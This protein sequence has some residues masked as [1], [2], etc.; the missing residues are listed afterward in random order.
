MSAE[1]LITVV[2]GVA[3]AAMGNVLY[4]AIQYLFPQRQRKE[5]GIEN[6]VEQLTRALK[7]ATGLIGNIEA[8]ITARSNLAAQYKRT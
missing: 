1:L 6:R 7:D 2:T 4:S 3:V 5:E 8:E